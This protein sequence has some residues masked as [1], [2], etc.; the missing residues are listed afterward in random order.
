MIYEAGVLGE[1]SAMAP[2]KKY[3]TEEEK[4]A[5]Q[6]AY[7]HRRKNEPEVKER[8]L[9]AGRKYHQQNRERER[10]YAK[11][12]NQRNREQRIQA[13]KDYRKTSNGVKSGII[14]NWK[15]LGVVCEN[16][17]ALYAEYKASTHCEECG[18]E[19][20]KHGDGTGTFRCLDHDHQTGIFRN[21]LCTKCNIRRGF[22]DRAKASSQEGE[23]AE[24]GCR[25]SAP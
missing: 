6:R 20:G 16:W 12:Y 3:F 1:Y 18:V 25:N 7:Y 5:A 15:K 17:D 2:P 24:K 23:L 14:G 9:A 11:Q 22:D 19:Y 4:R 10:E 13:N 21:F 8:K